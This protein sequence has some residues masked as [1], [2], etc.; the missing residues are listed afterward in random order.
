MKKARVK[1]ILK[2]ILPALLVALILWV[3]FIRG[4]STTVLVKKT[5]L[6]NRIVLKTITANG[7]IS[8]K[9]QASL[10]FQATG[11]VTRINVKEGEEV[12]KGQLLTSLDTSNLSQNVQ[13]YKDA[14]DIKIRQKELFLDDYKAN[15][16]ALGG[17]KRYNMKLREYEEG[18]SQAQAA[19]NAQLALYSNYNIYAP[20]DGIAIN[21]T[22]EVNETAAIGETIVEVADLNNLIFKIY[23]DQEDYGLLKEGQKVEIKLDSYPNEV[24]EGKVLPLPLF[25]DTG[26]EQFKV[27]IA[28]TPKENV[29]TRIGMK[30]DGYVIL[31]S[32]ETEVPSLSGDEVSYD[33]SDKPYVW[34]LENGKLKIKPVEFGIEG[35]VYVQITN[36]VPEQ[37][38]VT[39]KETQKM[40]EG[41]KAVVTN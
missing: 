12:K 18:V 7:T 5:Q 16:E 31:Q 23:V 14:L 4:K 20:F 29:Q 6:K 21:L 8:S 39:A 37:I 40:V 19:Y 17:D 15:K 33:D 24:L 28:V 27:E 11:K 1:N 2:M 35:D 38:V 25:V 3:F 9:S 26:T 13:Y 30:G 32:S 22:K 41:Y 10:S 36:E 34:I